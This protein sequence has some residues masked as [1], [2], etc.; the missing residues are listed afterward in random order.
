MGFLFFFLGT[1]LLRNGFMGNLVILVKNVESQKR[2][3][4]CSGEEW[5]HSHPQYVTHLSSHRLYLC[6]FSS[7]QKRFR[8]AS[9]LPLP[10]TTP[11]SIP[12]QNGHDKRCGSNVFCLNERRRLNFF[13]SLF[14]AS[15]HKVFWQIIFIQKFFLCIFNFI[16]QFYF[17][18][19]L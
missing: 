12:L 18:L 17:F 5:R 6:L 16:I 7:M 14:S 19:I 13:D 11:L 3:R 2:R 8:I 15:F 4:C 10:N 9:L 1:N